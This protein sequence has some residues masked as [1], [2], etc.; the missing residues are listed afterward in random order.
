MSNILIFGNSGSGKS[1]LAKSICGSQ[2]LAHLDLDLLAWEAT[3]P[4]QRKELS[5]SKIE[6]LITSS[7]PINL[8]LLRVVILIY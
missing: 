4:P 2:G 8:G 6:R 5:V 3:T 7:K 1:T